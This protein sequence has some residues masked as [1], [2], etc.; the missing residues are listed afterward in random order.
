MA[1]TLTSHSIINN[2]TV[3]R[4]PLKSTR[5]CSYP[6]ISS[7]S[8][9]KP[10]NLFRIGKQEVS[11]E[12]NNEAKKTSKFTLD[13]PNIPNLQSFI[14]P[15]NKST[16]LTFGG[17]RRKDPNTVFV[18][19]AT[20]QVGVRLS[21]ALLRR[22]FAVR[23]GVPDLSSAQ[24]LARL[25]ASYKII[26]PEES[27]RLN[28]LESSFRDAEAIAKAIGNASKAVVT[29]GPSENGPS[30]AVDYS[31]ALQIMNA[32]Q[33]AGVKHV[34]VICDSNPFVA[35]TYNV[36]DG[37]STFFSN[38]FGGN[39]CLTLQDFLSKVVETDVSYTVVKAGLTEDFLPESSYN[40]VVSCEGSSD[41]NP[42]KVSKYQVASLVA[43]VFG[44]TSIAENKVIEVSTSPSAP[45]QPIDQLLSVIPV[46]GR[47]RAYAEAQEK[48]KFEEEAMKATLKAQEAAESAKRLE[49][50]IQKLE[51]EE[52]KAARLVE[53]ANEK[54][55]AAGSS[56]EGLLNRAKTLGGDFSWAKL[57]SQIS[58][59]IS[60]NKPEQEEPKVQIATLRGQAKARALTPRKAVINQTRSKAKK[61]EP[62]PEVR[63][64][65]GGL[66]KQETIYV[67]DD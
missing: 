53:E 48:T 47:R 27:R 62:K 5:Q 65:F 13:F 37:I 32:A 66:F 10:N 59:T 54:A 33:L 18:A 61:T 50:E 67:D 60:K 4:L 29:I 12:P 3:S 42:Y 45:L 63:K 58:T 41:G 22:G 7:S 49:Q 26:S 64:V 31:D 39:Q 11:A 43:D 35:S 9:K 28:A 30:S 34:V 17:Q 16:A 2:S 44:N 14:T 6:F 57:S 55:Q 56:V 8:T 19:G 20:G 1:P 52:A 38:F 40:V 21:Q 15:P 51:V 25:A 23:A 36:L 46:D 24:E